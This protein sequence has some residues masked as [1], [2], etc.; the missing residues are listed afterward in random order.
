MAVQ[1]PASRSGSD[2]SPAALVAGGLA[3]ATA[4]G[5]AGGW[6]WFL[7]LAANFRGQLLLAGGIVLAYAIAR[8]R[9]PGVILLAV[10]VVAANGALIAPLYLGGRDQAVP[11]VQLLRVVSFNVAADNR[12]GRHEVVDFLRDAGAD[13][14]FLH[15]VHARWERVIVDAG[16]PYELHVARRPGEIFG[17]AAL[18]P[19]GT[20]V[21]QVDFGIRRS[22]IVTLDYAGRQV[23]LVG[24]HPLSP[25]TGRRASAR[26][27][28]LAA[29]AEWVAGRPGPV[30]VAGDLNAT[31]WTAAFRMLVA[32]GDLVSSQRGFGLQAS[33]P[34]L[35]MPLRIP[36]D[37]LLHS[38]DLV[39]VDR[40]LGPSAGSDHRALIVDL[41]P[42]VS[43]AASP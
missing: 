8:R 34:D 10:G 37:H 39:T 4:A 19:P 21:E 30:V 43:T 7:D 18:V 22:P 32:A 35:P 27:Q 9:S 6:W 29:V 14:V 12:A 23:E 11:S 16:L 31:P 40:R 33:W 36:I 25:I 15:E 20:T 42:A 24:V 17:T 2:L 28:Q 1:Q 5:F 13:V 26:D 38:D 41:A 3:V